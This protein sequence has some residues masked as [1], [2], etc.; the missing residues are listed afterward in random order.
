M[1]RVLP[2]GVEPLAAYFYTWEENPCPKGRV[3]AETPVERRNDGRCR[4]V[5]LAT[6]D[7]FL[8]VDDDAKVHIMN[9]AAEAIF[10][11][12]RCEVV[13]AKIESVGEP[14]LA[15]HLR[16]ALA[17][18][19][20]IASFWVTGPDRKLSCRLAPYEHDG[21]RLHV[22]SVR[23]DSELFR[24]QER[25]ESILS[26][27]G[28]GLIV[29]SM[30]D[31]VTYANLAACE[32]LGS[33]RSQLLD[34]VTSID[35]LLG[36]ER[37]VASQPEKCWILRGCARTDCAAYGSDDPRCWLADQTPTLDGQPA[38]F[39]EKMRVCATCDVFAANAP[40]VPETGMPRTREV[41]LA[42]RDRIARVTTNPVVDAL[43][44]YVGTVTTLADVTT[45][46]EVQQIKSEF[47]STVSHELRTPLTAIK[48]YVDLLMEGEAGELSET[49][50]EFLTIVKHNSDKLVGLINDLL[51]I[52]RI[53]SG[54]VHLQVV[55]VDLSDVVADTAGTFS[56]AFGPGG[57]SLDIGLPEDLPRIAAD[58]KRIG[59]VLTNLVSNAVKY[60]PHGGTVR[61][62]ARAE[63]DEV[64]VDV[65]DT[66]L[67]LSEEDSERVFGKFFRADS[68]S[69]QEVGG[70]GLGLA[71]CKSIVELHGGDIWVE[72]ELGTGSTFSFSIPV[73][74]PGLVRLPS[75]EGPSE[76]H[77]GLVLVVDGE[78]HIAD[79]TET[80]LV[81]RGYTVLKASTGRE[82]IEMIARN[83]PDAVTLDVMLSDMDGFELL[84]RIKADPE[85]AGIPVVVLS[86]VCDEGKSCRLGA[87]DY[88]EK[89]IDED[90]LLSILRRV[91]VSELTPHALVVDD[92]KAVVDR[93]SE[94]LRE[95]GFAVIPAYDG[96]EALAA[97]GRG[98]PD[99]V[100]LDL[101]MP[102]LDG[103]ELM[104]RIKTDATMRD[105]PVIVMTGHEFDESQVDLLGTA[106]DQVSKPFEADPIVERIESLLFGDSGGS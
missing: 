16:E 88:L 67:G 51:D 32:M 105:L 30:D 89:P 72:S 99:V 55:P 64:V 41:T 76:R 75:V 104:R 15:Q 8:I 106:A 35:E 26:S 22:L 91:L 56:A 65:A 54:R 66:G 57:L 12:P 92:D 69:T 86:V 18:D 43:G 31:C 68:S 95:R 96:H 17:A 47:V 6:S 83:R 50:R 11:R 52:S 34:T 36:L 84:Q 53:E 29:L 9:E 78:E 39:R 62:S 58:P 93:L 98:L 73:A 21:Q 14:H 28:E 71:I 97:L 46:R 5:L 45:E 44:R 82:A 48:G 23:D 100:L 103:Y 81:R 33:D 3:V 101:E 37:P 38:S 60:S 77:R 27:T 87:A 59:Q 74:P 85:T 1:P 102:E 94:L 70:T 4:A 63:V 42:D 13:G 24:E 49:Q 2:A 20:E 40:L 19:D 90:R 7:A 79:L 61:V 10:G 80:L 25:L